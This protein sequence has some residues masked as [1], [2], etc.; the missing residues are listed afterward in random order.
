M[1]TQAS[2]FTGSIPENYDA[3]LGPHIFEGYAD[4]L[5]RRVAGLRPNSVLELA[6]GTGIVSRKLRDAL[7]V[8]CE[9]IV[10][11]L[12][13]PMLDVARA[14]FRP[15]ERVGFEQIDATELGFEDAAFDVVVCQFGVMF[16]PDKDR[17]YREVHRVLK[18]GGSYVFNVW[19]GLAS[20]PFAQ[21]ALDTIGG[22][23]PDDPPRF[24][25]VPFGYHDT[26]AIKQSLRAAGFSAV[27][28]EAVSLTSEISSADLFARGLVFGN[29]AFEEMVSRGGD[30]EE[31]RVALSDAIR[32]NLGDSMPLS[33]FVIHAAKAS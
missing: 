17:S 29:P 1:S 15:G 3:G 8:D 11:D 32:R 7:A 9:L 33:A 30:P 2:R 20:N 27:T 22:F 4:D 13:P 21:L 24:Y 16:F 26:D 14:K 23:F 19:D 6:C 28:V 18:A 10:S 12:N 25:E 31:I 5:T